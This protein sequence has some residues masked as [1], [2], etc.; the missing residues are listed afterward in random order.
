MTTLVD[1]QMFEAGDVTL[2]SGAVF[3]SISLP[4]RPTAR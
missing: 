2:Q 4:T 1:Y 3:P